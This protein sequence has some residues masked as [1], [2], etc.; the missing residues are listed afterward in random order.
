M[1]S[2]KIDL[3]NNEVVVEEDRVNSVYKIGT[4]EAFNILSQAWLRCGWDNK[5]VYTFSWMGRPIIQL[6]EDIVRTQEVI[7][8]IEPDVII[9]TGIAHGGSLILYASLCKA[10]GRGKIIGIDIEIRSHNRAAIEEHNLFEYITLVEGSSVDTNIVSHVKSLIKPTDKVL[11][12][13]DSN[14]SREHVLAELNAYAELVSLGSYI[15]ATDGIMK[16]LVSAPRSQADWDTN[17]PYHAAQD[18]LGTHPEFK[19]EQ[20]EWAF[21]ESN[22]LSENVTYWPGAWLQRIKM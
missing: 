10:M 19:L 1:Q 12:I 4:P 11:I 5:Y 2:I 15:V 22:G 8:K 16:D 20:P 18:F 7:Y 21:N 17:N 13:L 3:E 9:E 6:P 14:H